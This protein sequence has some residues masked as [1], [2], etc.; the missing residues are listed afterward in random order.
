MMHLNDPNG[1]HIAGLASSDRQSGRTVGAEGQENSFGGLTE[2]QMLGAVDALS[3]YLRQQRAHYY[4]L[5]QPLDSK[6]KAFLARF[7]DPS[8]LGQVKIVSKNG[9]R[10]PNPPFLETAKKMGFKHLPDLKHQATV[11]FLDVVVFNEPFTERALFHGLV[12]AAQVQVLGIDRFA[13]LFLRGFL[14]SKSYFMIPLKAHAFTLDCQ[15]A[16]RRA[17]GFSVETEITRWLEQDRY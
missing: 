10:V 7:F 17:R 15:F 5:G 11:T 12:Y 4:P 14:R 9:E 6:S 16:E 8:L 13:G 2:Q 3:S 1:L